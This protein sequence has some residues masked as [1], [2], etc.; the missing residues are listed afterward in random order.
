MK[1]PRL[2]VESG[3]GGEKCVEREMWRERAVEGGRFEEGSVARVEERGEEREVWR[4]RCVEK[5]VERD[6]WREV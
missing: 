2:Q 3:S 1:T 5:G 6:V 4:K